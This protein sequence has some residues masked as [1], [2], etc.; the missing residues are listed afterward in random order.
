[1]R[2]LGSG[3]RPCYGAAEVTELAYRTPAE[4][5]AVVAALRRRA[6]LDQ[7]Q[8]AAHLGIDQPA[9]SRI[10][11]GERRLNAWEL[12]ALAELLQVEP[13]LILG[14]E[15]PGAALLRVAGAGESAVREAL[16]VFEMVVREV[17]AARAL[18]DLL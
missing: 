18:E 14:K 4:V 9:V 16:D 10:E 15:E 8:V 2:C 12:Y 13:G 11:R 3:R 7:S 17:L 1:M 5:G 6:G